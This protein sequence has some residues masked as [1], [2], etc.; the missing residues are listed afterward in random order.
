MIAR[1]ARRPR[2]PPLQDQHQPRPA[3]ED[4]GPGGRAQEPQPRTQVLADV[5][6]LG[7]PNAGKS[8][9][10]RAV[11]SAAQGGR[12]PFTTLAPTSAW[13]APPRTAAS[14]S[15]TS[16]ASSKAPPTAPASATSSCATCSEPTSCCTSS[17]WPLRPGGRPGPRRPRHRRRTP[18]VRRPLANKPPLAGAQQA[19]P[20]PRRRRA[21]GPRGAF[22]A[23]YGPVER[24]FEVSAIS[25]RLPGRSSSRSRTSSTKRRPSPRPPPMQ[26]PGKPPSAAKPKPSTTGDDTD[27]TKTTT[28][29]TKRKRKREDRDENP[30]Q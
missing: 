23:A 9:F 14:S 18:Q 16:P 10:I 13:C 2:Q 28:Q 21:Q 26:P 19:R 17:T 24:H 12:L 8:T 5:G 7:M 30:N 11:S 29:T 1:A 22:L 25:R 3:Q 27:P 20:D 6:L 15:P 4:H